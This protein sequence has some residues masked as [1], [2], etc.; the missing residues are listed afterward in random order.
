MSIYRN[1]ILRSEIGLDNFVFISFMDPKI[2]T[3]SEYRSEHKTYLSNEKV[4]SYISA[5]LAISAETTQ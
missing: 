3:L 1:Y 5:F 2:T 4:G